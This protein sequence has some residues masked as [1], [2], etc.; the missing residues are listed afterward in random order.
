MSLHASHF[1]VAAPRAAINQDGG[2]K[3]RK[4]QILIKPAV[5]FSRQITRRKYPNAVIPR[6]Y[7]HIKLTAGVFLRLCPGQ[8]QDIITNG[9]WRCDGCRNGVLCRCTG[10]EGG[11]SSFHMGHSTTYTVSTYI[12]L[13]IIKDRPGKPPA[14]LVKELPCTFVSL[15]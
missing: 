13:M 10:P 2:I 11:N 9:G 15:Y 7:F 1:P 3:I 5:A 4:T 8:Q 6:L 14:M 12:T